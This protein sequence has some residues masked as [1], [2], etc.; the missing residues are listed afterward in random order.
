MKRAAAGFLKNV[1]YSV[2]ANLISTGVSVLLVAIVPKLLGVEQYGYWQLYVF[3]SGYIGFFHFGWADGVYLRYGGN[4][5]EDLPKPLM[6]SQFRLLALFETLLMAGL[7]AAVLLSSGAA[8]KKAV[9]ALTAACGLLMLPRTLLQYLL[10]STGRIREYA[11][12]VVAEKLVYGALVAAFLLAGQRS[13][14]SLL[15]ADLAAKGVAL[16]LM[17]VS[18]RDVVLGRMAAWT[19]GLREALRNVGAGIQLMFANV[20]GLLIVGIVRFAI[21]RSWDVPTFGRV[22]LTLSVSNLLMLF[23]TAVS[24]VL[25]PLLKRIPEER[26]TAGYV[27]IRTSLFVPASG[28]L[29]LCWPV[30]ALL[31]LWLPQYAASLAYLP[32]LFPIVLY[33]GKM[34]LIVNTYMKA[35]RM[36]RTLLLVNLATVGAS[37]LAT[38]LSAFLLHDL[39]LAVGSIVLLLAFRCVL[40]ETVL[41]RRLGLRLG[42]DLAAE[43]VLTAV[44]ILSGLL[45]GGWAGVAAYAAVYAAYL[46]WKRPALRDAVRSLA[47]QVRNVSAPAAPTDPGPSAD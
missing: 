25:F 47:A 27:L 2:A 17:A 24:T 12:N 26:R 45:L 19:E 31:S 42:A 9:L 35:M 39:T 4:R 22:S 33:E 6:R 28:L 1:S 8:D 38:G 20:A 18:C 41:A 40:A 13:Y 7:A 3:Y 11:R 43:Q 15:A 10:Q 37:L 34:S 44:F 46:A 5:Y 29:L 32:L 30:G 36:E 14:P 16:V 23:I 21:E